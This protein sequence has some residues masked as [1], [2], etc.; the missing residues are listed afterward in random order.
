VKSSDKPAGE[1]LKSAKKLPQLSKNNR[2]FMTETIF[3]V[4]C[5]SINTMGLKAH[6]NKNVFF[7]TPIVYDSRK[8]LTFFLLNIDGAPNFV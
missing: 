8:K 4:H 1:I 6:F 5:V 3:A 7:T 2:Q